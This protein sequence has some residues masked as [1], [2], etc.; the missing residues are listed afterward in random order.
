MKTFKEY[1]L[2]ET[3]QAF[4]DLNQFK[5][6]TAIQQV[7]IPYALKGEDVIAIADTGTGK[8]HAFLIPIF[9]NINS[10]LN[11]VQAVIT[12]PTRELA[13]QIYQFAIKYKEVNDQLRIKL[14]TGG[15]DRKTSDIQPHMV[16]GTP[17]RIKDLFLNQQLRVETADV[18]VVDEADMTFEFGFLTDVD[19]IAGKMGE[20]LQMMVFSAT[21]PLEVQQ[22]LK[23][24]MQHPKTIKIEST[25]P[26]ATIDHILVPAKHQSY[27]EVVLRLIGGFQPY[28]C[29]IFANTR[30]DAAQVSEQLREAGLRVLEIHGG[31]TARARKQALKALQ[32]HDYEYVVA[33]DIAARGLD[34][35]GI[36]HVISLGFPTDLN[37]YIHRSGRTGRNQKH[38]FCYA[39]YRDADQHSIQ[40]LQNKGIVFHHR[41]IKNGQWSDLKPLFQKKKRNNIVEKEIAKVLTRKNQKV[42]PGYKKKRQA[43]IEKI[44]RQRRREAIKASIKGNQKERA[45]QKQ[46][47]KRGNS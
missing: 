19:A 38:G 12:A 15:M 11:R 24:Y 46:I 6:P 16:I 1:Q 32:N 2:K 45:K 3:T 35:E 33:T 36:T 43:E 18:L 39:V 31:L 41:D 21:I 42:K 14:V 13:R 20:Q 10:D 9:E 28:V 37:F 44:K 17:G 23:K 4:I 26:Q 29:L 34:I 22:F 30:E 27:A 47:A 8:T 7:V 5:E 25:T 40:A